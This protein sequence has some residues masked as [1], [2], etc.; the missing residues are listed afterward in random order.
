[1]VLGPIL[2]NNTGIRILWTP[3]KAQKGSWNATVEITDGRGG[4]AQQTFSIRVEFIGPGCTITNPLSGATV[5]GTLRIN[6]TAAKGSAEVARVEVRI[7]DGPWKDA[8]G[9]LGWSF[10]I[11]TTRLSNGN[12]T[13]EARSTDGELLS[14]PAAVRIIVGNEVRAPKPAGV[15]LEGSL[16]WVLAVVLCA[17]GLT[18]FLILKG[19]KNKGRE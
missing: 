13:I 19:R 16:W 8:S 7:D 6:G 2:A 1:M 15:T 4:S 10:D 5:N 9:T 17:A 11:D 18:A 14:G 3:S 12:H